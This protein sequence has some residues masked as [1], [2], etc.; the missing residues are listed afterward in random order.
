MYRDKLSAYLFYANEYEISP[1]YA[2]NRQI[3]LNT[4]YR[5]P[6]V[7]NYWLQV[8]IGYIW[9]LVGNITAWIELSSNCE[10]TYSMKTDKLFILRK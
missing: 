1:Q 8:K 4:L 7:I 3:C 2:R 6:N 10:N 5:R 9:N